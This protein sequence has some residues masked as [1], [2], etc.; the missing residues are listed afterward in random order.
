MSTQAARSVARGARPLCCLSLRVLNPVYHNV[1]PS[2]AI[3]L[4][5]WC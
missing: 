5:G 4:I 1:D 2:Y 3:R